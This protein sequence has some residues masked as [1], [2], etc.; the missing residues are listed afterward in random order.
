MDGDFNREDEDNI[1]LHMHPHGFGHTEV[2]S[3]P[4][5]RYAKQ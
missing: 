4:K 1:A 2:V 3:A 5:L